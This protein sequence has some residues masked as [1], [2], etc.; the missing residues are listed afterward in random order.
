[1]QKAIARSP[2][3][4]SGWT[5]PAYKYTGPYNPLHKKLRHDSNT[6]ETLEI[7]DQPTGATDFAA[8]QYDVDNGVCKDDGKC[9]NEAD[10]KMLKSLDAVPYK[11]K[12]WSHFLA[13]NMINTKQM[14]DIGLSKN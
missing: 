12:Q 11:D 10:R 6:E 4:R 9:K 8:M 1:M 7:W 2:K 13:R 3:P 14:Y 5:L